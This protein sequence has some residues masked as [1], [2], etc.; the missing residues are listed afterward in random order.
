MTA[1]IPFL[2]QGAVLAPIDNLPPPPAASAPPP[3]TAVRGLMMFLQK[4]RGRGR[5]EFHLPV[6]ILD[7]LPVMNHGL[8]AFPVLGLTIGQPWLHET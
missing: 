8:P 6:S 7:G 5:F 1:V 3:D 2:L 4:L